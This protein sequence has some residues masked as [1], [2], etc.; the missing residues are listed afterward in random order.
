[1]KKILF[2][3]IILTS[4]MVKSQNVSNVPYY[5]KDSVGIGTVSPL[6][7]LDVHGS[8][9]LQSS[10]MGKRW[11]ITVNTPDQPYSTALNYEDTTNGTINVIGVVDPFD[12]VHSN[13]SVLQAQHTSTGNSAFMIMSIDSVTHEASIDILAQNPVG[14]PAQFNILAQQTNI[15]GPLSVQDGTQAAGY[16]LTSDAAGNAIWAAPSGGSGWNLTGN[17][18]TDT[19]VNFIGTTDATNLV[20][21]VNST[22]VGLLSEGSISFGTGSMNYPNATERHNAAFGAGAL[23]HITTGDHNVSVGSNSGV[24]LTT[25]SSNTFLGDGANMNAGVSHSVVLGNSTCD[26]SNTI[27]ADQVT[28]ITLPQMAGTVAPTT[29]LDVNNTG[30]YSAH[31]ISDGLRTFTTPAA[32]TTALGSG[33]PY[34]LSTT[35]GVVA[36][37]LLAVSP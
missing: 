3:F 5:F 37:L 19:S 32:A 9:H 34:I 8:S 16:V 17:A 18:G 26:T 15:L 28:S 30:R 12:G 22:F 25:E 7:N 2:A 21:K 35:I 36:V 1:M 13:V 24:A 20:F 6:A 31:Y 10:T 23:S 27:Y 11:Y 14:N 29:L 4:L 33:F